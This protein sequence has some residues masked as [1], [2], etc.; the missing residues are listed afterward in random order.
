MG[1]PVNPTKTAALPSLGHGHHLIAK[2]AC[3]AKAGTVAVQGWETVVMIDLS[4]L[5]PSSS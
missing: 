1:I 2:E 5:I 3:I 4:V